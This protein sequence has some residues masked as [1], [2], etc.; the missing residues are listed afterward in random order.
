MVSLMGIDE[1][2]TNIAGNMRRLRLEKGLTQKGL[3]ERFGVSMA[4]L[5]KFGQKGAISF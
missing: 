5:R 1:A 3:A 4:N 2:Q